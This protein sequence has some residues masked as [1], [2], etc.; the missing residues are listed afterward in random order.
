MQSGRDHVHRT[1]LQL[2][3]VEA[4]HRSRPV[5]SAVRS[6]RVVPTSRTEA[7]LFPQRRTVDLSVSNVRMLGKYECAPTLTSSTIEQHRLIDF[8][9]IPKTTKKNKTKHH[10][11]ISIFCFVF[12]PLNHANCAVWR[13]WLLE[14]WVSAVDLQQSIAIGA[15][16]LLSALR[17]RSMQLSNQ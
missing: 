13:V 6:Q 12:S 10:Y 14:T 7:C 2:L 11:V 16:R 8:Y 1:G 9:F 17:R 4:R 3:N 15:R 5:L